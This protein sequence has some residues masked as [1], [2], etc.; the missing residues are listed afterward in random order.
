MIAANDN[1]PAL[2]AAERAVIIEAIMDE[3]DILC[4]GIP[5]PERL[6]SEIAIRLLH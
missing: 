5:G 3:Y 4:L 1:S 2:T 6:E